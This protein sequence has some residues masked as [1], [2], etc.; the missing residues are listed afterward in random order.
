MFHLTRA[1]L[2]SSDPTDPN[3]DPAQ[4]GGAKRG[5]RADAQRNVDAL[6]EAAKAV[7][8]VSG[9]DAPVREISQQAGVGVGTFY[10]HFPDRA[11][12]IAAVFRREVDACADAAP[13]LSA[14]H[15]PFEA[16]ARWI[17]LFAGFITTK[18]GL[19]SALHSGSPAFESLPAYFDQRLRPTL[20]RLLAAAVASGQARTDVEADDIIGAVASLCS[21]TKAG[22]PDHAQR[23][24][25]LFVDGLRLVPGNQQ[26]RPG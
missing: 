4:H 6:L 11:G 13:Q 5:V 2:L 12:L 21:A 3:A 1:N 14:D 22:K 9:V 17:Q 18:R 24:I 16:M 8:A 20:A 25:A 26:V 19:A 10:R 15:P 23:M 7:F